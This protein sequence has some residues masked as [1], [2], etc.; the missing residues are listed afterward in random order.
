MWLACLIYLKKNNI[1]DLLAVAISYL[2]HS[3]EYW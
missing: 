3:Y 1:Y 2:V